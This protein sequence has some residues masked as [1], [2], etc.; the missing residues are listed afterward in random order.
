M[1][2]AVPKVLIV[3][4][5]Q[6]IL[7]ILSKV[8]QK[9]GYCVDT[10]STALKALNKIEAE[11]YNAALIDVRLGDAN[12]LDLLNEIQGV[13]PRMVKIMLT[14]YPSEEDRTEAFVRGADEYLAKPVKSEKLIE[15]IQSKLG[16]D[17]AGR[18][19]K[20]RLS[21]LPDFIPGSND[22]ISKPSWLAN[23]QKLSD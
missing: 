3:D 23:V 2:K 20:A 21:V 13:A 4:D 14:G 7:K 16:Q 6:T 15:I 1:P 5:D 11:P 8:L 18:R 12:G 19:C 10:A 9:K 22:S 17:L